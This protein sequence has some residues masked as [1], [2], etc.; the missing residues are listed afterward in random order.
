VS[1]NLALLCIVSG[2]VLAASITPF[3]L[4]IVRRKADVFNPVYSFSIY[5]GIQLGLYPIYALV[6]ER[7]LKTMDFADVGDVNL[8]LVS[9]VIS[10]LGLGLFFLGYGSGLGFNLA[11]RLPA[12]PN[13]SPQRMLL[14]LLFLIPVILGSNYLAYFQGGLTAY[15][16]RFTETRYNVGSRTNA[17]LYYF[18]SG[19]CSLAAVACFIVSR[20]QAGSTFWRFLSIGLF[21]TALISSFLTGFRAALVP[22]V[23]LVTICYHYLVKPFSPSRA[24]VFAFTFVL[25]LVAY[26]IVREQVEA[27]SSGSVAELRLDSSLW[28]TFVLRSPGTEM[29]AATIDGT[30]KGEDFQFF[31]PAVF[32]AVTIPVPRQLWLGKPRPQSLVWGQ[33]FMDYYLFVRDGT[34]SENTGGLSMTIVGYLYWQGGILAVL[35]GMYFCGVF[36]RLIY[37]ML[38]VQFNRDGAIFVFLVI[39]SVTPRLAEAPQ[40]AMNAMMLSM[41]F[42]GAFFLFAG[43]ADSER[44]NRRTLSEELKVAAKPGGAAMRANRP[45]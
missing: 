15:F 12:L 3:V 31:L 17:Y 41:V 25:G 42:L 28:D 21:A 10:L 23:L 32:E 33:T 27:S 2:L 4:S 19:L 44:V 43:S 16:E 26:G 9:A 1:L 38:M 11:R 20:R 13:L 24:M 37:S 14:L 36:F 29:V 40:D 8:M 30:R 6:L 7:P 34:Q 5:Y 22:I 45:A 35:A 39:A 18:A